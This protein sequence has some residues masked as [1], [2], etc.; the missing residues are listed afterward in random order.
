MRQ[1]QIQQDISRDMVL[2]GSFDIAAPEQDMGRPSLAARLQARLFASRFDRDV[3]LGAVIIPGTPLAL[4][5]ARITSMK[6]RHS[7]ARA[8]RGAVEV[9]DS[10]RRG[11]SARVPIHSGQVAG[12]RSEI[13]QI[14]SL[15]QAPVPVHPRGMARLRTLLT[16]GGGPLYQGGS[17]SLAAE[18]RA[19]LAAL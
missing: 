14:T 9:T 1:N 10:F 8:L 15:L 2:D 7:L 19:V 11:V 16:N 5:V 13:E 6:E 17:G 4:H 18:L 3:E 12:C